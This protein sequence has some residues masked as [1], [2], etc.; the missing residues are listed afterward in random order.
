MS[1]LPSPSASTL[2]ST[3]RVSLGYGIAIAVSILV[4]ISTIML[5]SY[6]CARVK[7]SEDET[8]RHRGRSRRRDGLSAAEE[9][10]VVV[11]VGLDGPVVESYPKMILG[12]SKRLPKP[13][14]DGVCCICLC[15]YEQN[16]TVRCVPECNHC[17]HA[18]CVDGWLRI[19]GTCPTCRNSPV[20]SAAPTP[21]SESAPLAMHPR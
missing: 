14:Q 8:R 21:L 18:E 20:P 13:N 17:F 6:A 3:T 19:N 1:T 15:E 9:P 12:R 2:E 11:V 7:S 10:V 4:L 16:D 5:A